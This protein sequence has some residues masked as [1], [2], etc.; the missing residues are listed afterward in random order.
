M[1]R[2]LLW[3]LFYR[4]ETEAQRNQGTTRKWW[5]WD[6]TRQTDFS[7]HGQNNSAR[8]CHLLTLMGEVSQG[9]CHKRYPYL[10]PP[11]LGWCGEFLVCISPF[12]I[13][14]LALKI[15]S[16]CSYGNDHRATTAIAWTL[17][18]TTCQIH[19]DSVYRYM[20]HL[21]QHPTHTHIPPDTYTQYC[22]GT[23]TVLLWENLATERWGHLAQ[24]HM[25]TQLSLES[26]SPQGPALSTASCVF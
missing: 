9:C 2:E 26:F 19:K 14:V 20:G 6:S 16:S 10:L 11:I 1:R 12:L 24:G 18:M 7:V 23:F 5:I 3:Y 4:Q 15:N 13:S 8:P 17:T 22:M 21:M 25:A